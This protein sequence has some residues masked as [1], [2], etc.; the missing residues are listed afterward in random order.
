M[1]LTQG[2]AQAGAHELGAIPL[3]YLPP[4]QLLQSL[5]P[6]PMQLTQGATHTGQVLSD[7][8]QNYPALQTL[9]HSFPFTKVKVGVLQTEH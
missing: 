7:A 8:L 3:K 1:Q 9:L 5:A 6:I 4:M 2:E